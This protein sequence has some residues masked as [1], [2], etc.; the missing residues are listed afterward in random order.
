MLARAVYRATLR[1][2]HQIKKSGHPLQLSPP[3]TSE[4]WGTH[5]RLTPPE[6]EEQREDVFPWAP[7]DA[8]GEA[9]ALSADDLVRLARRRFAEPVDDENAAQDDALAALRALHD[10]LGRHAASSHAVSHGVRVIASATFLGA[11]EESGANLFAYR[12]RIKNERDDTVQLRSRHWV[13]ADE[14]GAEDE[15]VPKGS[16]GVVGQT[17]TLAPGAEFQYASGTELRGPK[18]AIRGSFEFVSV[19][20]GSTFEA[21]VRPF[22]LVAPPAGGAR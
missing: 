5:T 19:G 14:D 13:I 4:E 16:H 1:G 6:L 11:N 2:V 21:E 8:C 18:G 10:L 9:G 20:D 17:P 3:V 22:A 12:L 15:V 7:A